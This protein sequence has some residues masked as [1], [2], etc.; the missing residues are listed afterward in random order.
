VGAGSIFLAS[1][2]ENLLLADINP[3]LIALYKRIQSDAQGFLGDLRPL[4]SEEYRSSKAFLRLRQQYNSPT[5]SISEKTVLFVYINKFGFNGLYRMNRSGECNTSYGHPERVPTLPDTAILSF[6]E[7][8]QQAELHC[9]DFTSIMDRALFGDVVYCDPPYAD[10]NDKA[11]FNAYGAANFNWSDQI[12]LANKA[13]NLAS[14]GITVVISNHDTDETR[15]LY[16]GATLHH[17]S[18]RRSVAAAS[19]ARGQVQELVAVFSP[20]A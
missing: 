17:L 13:R 3:V 18:V 8:L 10:Q 1:E 2:F 4:F 19:S 15:N 7:R 9:G 6:A 14:K 5:T 11:S 20:S 16:S 12:R